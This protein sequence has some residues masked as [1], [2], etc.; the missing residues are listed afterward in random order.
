MQRAVTVVAL[1][2]VSS[3]AAICASDFRIVLEDDPRSQV[4]L[5]GIRT[6]QLQHLERYTER[7]PDRHHY[8]IPRQQI[9]R[10]TYY[11]WLEASGHFAYAEGQGPTKHHR[12]G[13]RHFMPLL[14]KERGFYNFPLWA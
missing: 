1:F 11:Q 3:C 5:A 12:T 13:V 8:P 14:A 2:V 4:T 10:E 9:T 7:S 6:F